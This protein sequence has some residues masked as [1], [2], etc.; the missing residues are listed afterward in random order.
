LPGFGP[1]AGGAIATHPKIDKVAFT[2][3]TE[4]GIEVLKASASSG[5]LKRCT[6]ELGGKSP[7]IIFADSDIDNAIQQSHVGLFLNQGQC[8]IAAS[9][10]FVEKKVYDEVVDKS[11][12]LAK[13]RVVGDPADPNTR[14]GPQVDKDQ[15]DKVMGFIQKGKKEGAKLTVGGDRVG[16]KGYFIQPTVF[17]DVKDTMTIATDEIFGPVMSIL[18][19][20]D[21]DDVIKRA[22]STKYGLGASIFTSD[23]RKAHYFTNKL[24]AGTVYVNCY[25][26][27]DAAAPFGGFKMSGLGRELGEDGL[28]PYLEAKTVISK[29][30]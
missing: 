17:A 21:V 4:I 15:F 26:V 16:N 28:R 18:P 12:K 13:A 19:F 29:V 25:D 23:I 10:M 5:N 20:S 22:N 14:Q 1:T 9:R 8:C 6:L 11:T 3:S 7:N 24:R 30:V 2:G 27:F